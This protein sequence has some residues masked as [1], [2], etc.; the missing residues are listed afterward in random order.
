[1]QNDKPLGGL[2]AVSTMK[3]GAG[4]IQ[5]FN[6]ELE[7]RHRQFM[8]HSRTHFIKDALNVYT[9]YGVLEIQHTTKS[10]KQKVESVLTEADYATILQLPMVASAASSVHNTC[11]KGTRQ[12]VLET[13]WRW[14][15]NKESPKP[16][17]WLCDI[18]G[19][20]KSTI[21]MSAV[22]AW[23]NEGTLGGTFFFSMAISEWSNTDKFCS[24]LARE[25]AQ[26]V[27]NL[28]PYIAKAWKRNPA[29]LRSSFAEQFRILIAESL[30]HQQNPV[31]LVIDAIDE[32]KSG[33]QRKELVEALSAAAQENKNLRIFITSRP[34]PIIEKAKLT[35][36]LH[37]TSHRDNVEDIAIYVH[38]SLGG[39]LS[40]DKRR[41]LVNK[42]NGLFIWASTA[43]RML[44]DESLAIDPEI[45][46]DRLISIDQPGAIDGVYDLVIARIDQAS[47]PAIIEMLGMLLAAFEP[48]TSDDL[49]N[50]IKH[51]KGQ[52][53]AKALVRILGTVLKEDPITHLIQFRHPT[54]V[55][56]LQRCCIVPAVDVSGRIYINIS[57]AHGQV[58][59]WCLSGLRSRTEGLKFNICQIE[60]SFYLNRQIPDLEARVKKYISRRLRYASLHWP[61]HVSAMDDG[62]GHELQS[63]LAHIVR[64]PFALYWM[65]VLSVTGGVMRAISGLRAAAQH[66]RVSNL[67]KNFRLLKQEIDRRRNKASDE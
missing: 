49:E 44:N 46:Y 23:K 29:V 55:E 64:S 53:S 62:S 35:D 58:A 27:P 63:E 60:S 11:L 31:M 41:R 59:S 4:D 65:E 7:D 8:Q 33:R 40:S 48:L 30:Q 50:I 36:R 47:K 17:F 25:L 43:C 24:T 67:S 42:A 9:A 34:D 56:Y 32:C 14:A 61:F 5:K 6:R 66:Q 51:A 28:A 22:E 54:F 52:G 13:I 3:I 18:A 26:Y 39:I 2:T 1:M 21:A 15:A 20:G 19:S 16:I 45:I 37:D 57:H 12:A 38:Q 10:I